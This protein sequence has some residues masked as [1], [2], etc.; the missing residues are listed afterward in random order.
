MIAQNRQQVKPLRWCS[1]F[2]VTFNSPISHVGLQPGADQISTR[3]TD[4][5]ARSVKDKL[6]LPPVDD[7]ISPA[8]IARREALDLVGG[9]Q[10]SSIEP[11]RI[12]RRGSEDTVWGR[13][14]R[15]TV[16]LFARSSEKEEPEMQ[17]AN[18]TPAFDAVIKDAKAEDGDIIWTKRDN[19]P[20]RLIVTS[21]DGGEG[22]NSRSSLEKKNPRTWLSLKPRQTGNEISS[23]VKKAENDWGVGGGRRELAD[24]VER[25]EYEW[26]VGGNKRD[27]PTKLPQREHDWAVAGSK[28]DTL[29]I[30]PREETDWHIGNGHGNIARMIEREAVGEDISRNVKEDVFVHWSLPPHDGKRGINERNTKSIVAVRT[31]DGGGG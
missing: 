19:I 7:P 2:P 20:K 29:T 30:I 4:N 6:P 28:R 9:T 15:R 26:T 25:K 17:S 21:R 16:G 27:T 11:A 12:A 13:L 14:V 8:R 3:S 24:L 22:P 23:I 5:Q 31:E 18:Q 1:A 10:V